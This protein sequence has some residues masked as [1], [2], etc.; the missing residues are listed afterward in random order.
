MPFITQGK[1]NIIY[2]LIVVIIT[3]ITVSAIWWYQNSLEQPYLPTEIKQPEK[4][5]RDETVGWQ[6]YKDEGLGFEIRYPTGWNVYP[7]DSG[8]IGFISAG[9]NFSPFPESEIAKG[10]APFLDVSIFTSDDTLTDIGWINPSKMTIKDLIEKDK[11]IN[12]DFYATA[13]VKITDENLN[14]IPAVK[15][16]ISKININGKEGFLVKY[17]L[18]KDDKKFLISYGGP[19]DELSKIEDKFK[20]MLSTFKF[21]E[22]PEEEKAKLER[23]SRNSTRWNQMNA[24]ATAVY[25]YTVEHG[26]NFP[27]CVK[28]TPVDV[29]TCNELIIGKYLSSFPVPPQAPAEKY[30]IQKEG[31]VGIKITSTAKEAIDS[32]IEVIQ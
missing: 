18:N 10:A 25:S 2:I 29:T 11:E 14:N 28:T 4:T 5:T 26:G 30:M 21:I 12:K 7:W 19:I 13:E 8:G 32:K 31:S 6:T 15:E 24:I 16:E 20:Q 22:M 1:T 9:T 17:Y 23:A 3:I 27:S